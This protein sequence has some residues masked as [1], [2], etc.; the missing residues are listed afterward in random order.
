MPVG[1]DI[2]TELLAEEFTVHGS[3]K[4]KHHSLFCFLLSNQ[5]EMLQ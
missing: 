2:N 1:A 5:V 3:N 4:G